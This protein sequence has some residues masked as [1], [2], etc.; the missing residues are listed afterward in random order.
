[1]SIRIMSAVWDDASYEG[2]TLLV[3]LALADWA[4]DEG[5]CW[6]SVGAIAKKVRLSTRQV[7]RIL[8]QFEDE[9]VIAIERGGGRSVSNR[10]RLNMQNIL[11]TPNSVERST[12]TVTPVSVKPKTVTFAIETVTW[13]SQNSDICDSAIRKNRQEPSIEPSG[14]S[15]LFPEVSSNSKE[16]DLEN[17]LKD[18]FQYYVVQ[19]ERDPARYELNAKRRK[20]G[21]ARLRDCM[22]KAKE[23]KLENAAAMMKVAVDRLARSP[24][25]NGENKQGRCYLEWETHFLRKD[26]DEFHVFWVEDRNWKCPTGKEQC[27]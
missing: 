10:Y 17:A 5:Y 14:A 19:T 18:V 26:W 1:V 4:N 20:K 15:A 13:A 22:E 12:E 25:H 21:L 9:D 8:K 7:H 2:G 6:P 27:V 16:T 3:L 23:P 11:A 24:L